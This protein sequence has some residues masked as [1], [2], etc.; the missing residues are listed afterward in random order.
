MNYY[1]VG[2]KLIRKGSRR[3]VILYFIRLE[4]KLSFL[5]MVEPV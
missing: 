4:I 2:K 3:N 5:F 1:P